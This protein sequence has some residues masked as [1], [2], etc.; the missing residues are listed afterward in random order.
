LPVTFCRCTLSIR[1][2]AFF[3]ISIERGFFWYPSWPYSVGKILSLLGIDLK[4]EV[5]FGII[6][7]PLSYID[8][9][10]YERQNL[11]NFF[12]ETCKIGCFVSFKK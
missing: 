6:W 9:F 5:V 7:G 1:Q 12:Y 4:F 3:E 8:D 2:L 11:I 10:L